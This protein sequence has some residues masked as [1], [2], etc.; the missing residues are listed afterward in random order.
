MLLAG[1]SMATVIGMYYVIYHQAEMEMNISIDIA[2]KKMDDQNFMNQAELAPR[3][4]SDEV[5]LPGVVL[6][7]ENEEGKLVY[8][9][10][11]HFPTVEVLRN[12]LVDDKALWVSNKYQLVRLQHFMIYYYEMPMEYKGQQYNLIFSRV[13]TAERPMFAK[14]QER[15]LLGGIIGILLVVL[16]TGYGGK[17]TDSDTQNVAVNN[18]R[19]ESVGTDNA[20]G[21]DA[22]AK[23]AAGNDSGSGTTADTVSG[24]AAGDVTSNDSGSIAGDTGAGD[25]GSTAA[26]TDSGEAA[27]KGTTAGAA[28]DASTDAP[29]DA[30][31]E[32]SSDSKTQGT[33]EKVQ[34]ETPVVE[35]LEFEKKDDYIETK[36]GVNLRALPS[37]SDTVDIIAVF[38][39]KSR[40]HRTGATKEWNR[41]IY[42]DKE[43]YVYYTVVTGAFDEKEMTESTEGT[44]VTLSTEQGEAN[45]FV[46]CID[47]GHQGKGNSDKE[48]LGP[49]S[50]EMK[51]KVS[52]G[53]SGNTSGY[54]EY[55]LNLDIS[56]KLKKELLARGYTVVMTRETHDVDIS[57]AE[58]SQIAA[59]AGAGAF[60][61]I[62]ANSSTDT[63]VNGVETICMTSE[64]KY[65]AE[66]YDVS[67]KLSD[68]VL[69]NVVSKTGAKKRYVWET[70]TMT[71]I[72][73]SEVPV[74]ILEMGYM[75]NADE[76][77]NLLDE[78][79]Q[80]KIVLGIA[81][82][83]DEFF[84]IK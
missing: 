79:Y 2:L 50:S 29:S 52:S 71:G 10:D 59:D 49:G 51:A 36:K 8:D 66:L 32:G 72:N 20:A 23:D 65:N 1:A 48:P 11:K 47:P 54:A 5:L 3:E 6:R 21:S 57:N 70:D 40:L 13:I 17:D 45:G 42:D 46:V 19:D 44:T 43:C 74:T 76:E 28:G 56:L 39:G 26:G 67:R 22:I 25:S 14:I 69:N 73:W 80:N 61:R 81:D 27:G 83:L 34:P 75:S 16:I 84:G 64:N 58:R 12:N 9:S 82:G 60:V 37:L 41:V 68:C 55:K 4:A 24:D 78:N 15:L 63:S 30:G 38:D 35:V 33:E 7:V 77:K 53:T 18:E 62:H 31:A